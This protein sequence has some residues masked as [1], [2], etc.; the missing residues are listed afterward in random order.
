MTIQS[1]FAQSGIAINEWDKLAKKMIER[2]QR[3]SFDPATS[4]IQGMM[5]IAANELAEKNR[6]QTLKNGISKEWLSRLEPLPKLRYEK[7]Y[8]IPDVLA[9][10]GYKKGELTAI[11]YCMDSLNVNQMLAAHYYLMTDN[12]V[13]S[14]EYLG[15]ARYYH[16]LLM[17]V[18]ELVKIN[19]RELDEYTGYNKL[20]EKKIS[21]QLA[22]QSRMADKRNRENG[23]KRESNSSRRDKSNE[24][25]Q[26]VSRFQQQFKNTTSTFVLV[27]ANISVVADVTLILKH[28]ES[29]KRFSITYDKSF[30]KGLA[31]NDKLQ[32]GALIEVRFDNKGE[33]SSAKNP[34]N[35]FVVL[36][37][38]YKVTGYGW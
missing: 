10:G 13:K 16:K 37:S 35:G 20:I 11:G 5:R 19:K 12:Y 9:L 32:P 15:S 34:L 28:S 23:E 14:K 7:E 17:S 2:Q 38:N 22:H 8:E 6:A 3:D 18:P 33:P 30:A 24:I 29:G 21:E 25:A 31:G 36:V 26:D 27:S 1:L 4:E